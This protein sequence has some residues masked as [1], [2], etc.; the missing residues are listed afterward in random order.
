M[1]PYFG[2]FALTDVWT[3]NDR[4][5]INLGARLDHFV[6][7]FDDT[8][9]GFPARRFGSTRTTTKIAARPAQDPYRVERHAVRSVPGRP[10]PR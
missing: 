3:P 6:Y 2:S 4:L 9:S 10:T 8:V 7:K 5:L 1:R